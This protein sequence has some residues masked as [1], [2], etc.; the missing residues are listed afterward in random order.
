MGTLPQISA[1]FAIQTRPGFE[2]TGPP[3][4]KISFLQFCGSAL[5]KTFQI[6]SN[7]CKFETRIISIE[8]HP[9]N[10]KHFIKLVED[11]AVCSHWNKKE[12]E[13]GVMKSLI[14]MY[15]SQMGTKNVNIPCFSKSSAKERNK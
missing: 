13:N 5:F 11:E 10:L 7:L 3:D 9:R 15:W 8:V 6:S 14:L 12:V 1:N 4:K 2:P